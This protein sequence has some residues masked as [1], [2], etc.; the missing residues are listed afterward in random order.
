M[1]I[2][3][4]RI[5]LVAAILCGC[6]WV[7]PQ[8]YVGQDLEP[9]DRHPLESSAAL[10][11]IRTNTFVLSYRRQ[12][13]SV[14][15]EIT[16]GGQIQYTLDEDTHRLGGIVNR[17]L[18]ET[19]YVQTLF[20]DVTGKVIAVDAFRLYPREIKFYPVK[21]ENRL[22]LPSGAAMLTFRLTTYFIDGATRMV[23]RQISPTQTEEIGGI[24]GADD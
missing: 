12:I 11:E 5:L 19:I 23:S 16:L 21:F 20:A 22:P 1:Y 3:A 24:D 18:L 9:L 13:D 8:R 17:M 6:A 2:W 15:N 14:R 10:R 7:G 4:G